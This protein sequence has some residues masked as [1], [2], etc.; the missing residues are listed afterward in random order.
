M[1]Q[2]DDMQPPL[3]WSRARLHAFRFAFAIAG[4]STLELGIF[5]PI[6]LVFSALTKPAATVLSRCNM[7]EWRTTTFIGAFLIRTA[8]GGRIPI[9]EMMEKSRT[10]WG[11]S[12]L[13]DMVGLFALA[14]LIT[15]AWSFVDRR[16]SSYSA[17]NRCMRVYLRYA[18]GTAMLTYAFIKIIPTQFG[19]LTPGELLRPLGQLSRMQL[20]WD[21]M[22][23]SPAYTIFSGLIELLG[24]S[25]LFFRRTTLL[26]A[27]ILAGALTNVVVMD[28]AYNVGAVVY[29]NMLFLLDMIVLAPYLPSLA[30]ILVVHGRGEFTAEPDPLRQRWYHSPYAKA[31]FLCFLV[32]PLVQI[33]VARWRGFFGAGQAIYGLFDVTK[34]ARNGQP[35]TPL[36]SDSATWKRV[37]SDFRDG[38]TGFSVQFANGDVSQFRLTDDTVHREWTIRRQDSREVDVLQ[39][40]VQPDGDVSLDGHVG[41]DSVDMLLHPVDVHKIFPLLGK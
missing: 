18:L 25:L 11:L 27:L 1:S 36:A 31:G 3:Q 40:A 30:E 39:Y 12:A 2:E 37:A 10:D 21:F 28:I 41:R 16:R 35:I 17:L 24:A 9:H 32:L 20:L 13:P 26:G 6:H 29:A 8:T 38:I 34:F 14:S 22:A 15:I 7:L 23:A 5:L 19:Y 33:N 4:I